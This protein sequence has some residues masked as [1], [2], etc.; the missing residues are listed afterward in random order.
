MAL[1]ALLDE[2]VRFARD[3]RPEVNQ[4]L[5]CA[6]AC[7]GDYQHARGYLYQAHAMAPGRLEVY[8]ALYKFRLYRGHFDE[9]D[10][11][12][13]EALARQAWSLARSS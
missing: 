13:L 2:R 9:A 3:T 10:Q 6:V 1:T 11:I 7:A 5:Q 12:A 4:L 8:V